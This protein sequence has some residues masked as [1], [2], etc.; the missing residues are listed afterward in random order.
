MV[1]WQMD[2]R[3]VLPNGWRPER[4]GELHWSKTFKIARPPSASCMSERVS[5][6]EGDELSLRLQSAKTAASQPAISL[7]YDTRYSDNS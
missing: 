6:R 7:L 2:T 4:V 1:Q 5:L 3:N